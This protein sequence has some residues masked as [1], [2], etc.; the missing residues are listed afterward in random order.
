MTF[1]VLMFC[2]NFLNDAL[3]L[4]VNLN[5]ECIYIILPDDE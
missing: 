4:S 5:L 3:Y 2:L 1:K